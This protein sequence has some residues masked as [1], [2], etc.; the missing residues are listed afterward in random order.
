[1][2]LFLPPKKS[3]TFILVQFISALRTN[4]APLTKKHQPLPKILDIH[5][6]LFG[7]QI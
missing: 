2:Y 4:K 7:P 5:A 3:F 1:M 6:G